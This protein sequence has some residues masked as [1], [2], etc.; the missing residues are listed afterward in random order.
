MTAS[1]A[2]RIVT[3]DDHPLIRE[4]L[5][6]LISVHPDM[7]IVGE[8]ADGATAIRLFNELQPDVLLLDLQM[9]N[10]SGLEVIDRLIAQDPLARIIVLTT[11]DTEQLAAKAMS[12]GASAYI[13]KSS[14]GRRLLDTIRAV[15]RGQRYIDPSVASAIQ[16]HAHAEELTSRETDV[17]Q[18]IS[19]GNSNKLIGEQLQISEQT[20][21]GHVKNIFL[22][23]GANDRA[24]AVAL[25]V[26]RGII[27]V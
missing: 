21:K 18:L 7:S 16:A 5:S 9:P 8:A 2:I 11:Y 3:A 24:H 20:V 25:A 10:G 12:A 15:M 14:V 26:K 19:K 6:A 27:H 17:L 22:K 4:G 1:K 23:L 13:L